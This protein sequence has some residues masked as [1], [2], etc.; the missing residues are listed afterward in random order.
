[1]ISL[2]DR[3]AITE[4]IALHGHLVDDSRLEELNLVFA[5]DMTHELWMISFSFSFLWKGKIKRT[6]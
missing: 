4:L 1:M 6:S 2:E 5:N 3:S